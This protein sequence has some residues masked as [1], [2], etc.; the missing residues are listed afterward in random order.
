MFIE[1]EY[2]S[3]ISKKK[4]IDSW[5]W[6]K[7]ALNPY[8]GCMFGCL[9]CDGRSNK[10]FMPQDFECK[11]YVKKNA[12]SMLDERISKARTFLPDVVGIGGVTDSYQPAEKKYMVSKS[13]LEVLLKHKFP[14][15]ICTK[16]ELILRDKDI[17]KDISEKS[18]CIVSVTITS[19]KN[20]LSS[21]FEK[22]APLPDKRLKVI[23]IIKK[24]APK[25]QVGVLLM[26]VIPYFTD[27][28]NDLELLISKVKD[29]G[30]D[31]ILFSAGLTMR[32]KQAVWFLN[33]IK[34]KYEDKMSGFE[35][36]YGFKYNSQSYSGNYNATYKYYN[37]TTRKIFKLL[38]K[39]NM[40]YR[41]KRY[42]PDD[43]RRLNYMI[44]ERMFK[45]M[46]E[47]DIQG[48][49]TK[50]LFWAANNIQNLKESVSDIYE[51]GEL[52]KIQNIQ[53]EIKRG[54]EHYINKYSN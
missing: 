15:H 53:G 40:P 27:N 35:K 21:F 39:Y 41:I 12:A 13:I 6:D 45:K 30:A 36:L 50:E 20:D 29:A 19:I 51:R 14:V 43:Y 38:K 11:I 2:K 48:K 28:V 8:N 44:S 24:N 31:Y 3:I 47:L 9:Y 18:Y 1:K 52:E 33:E 42:I 5:F 16:S 10:Y 37:E 7:Y 4:N 22:R 32:D 34:E 17:L 49:N 46:Y 25:A 26:P 54:V 23:N